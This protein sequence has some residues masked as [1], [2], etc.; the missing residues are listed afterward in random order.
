MPGKGRW[1]DGELTGHVTSS[2]DSGDECRMNALFLHFPSVLGPQPMGLGL[3]HSVYGE[4]G[5]P[6]SGHL[7][8]EHLYK[9]PG[10]C[11]HG[12]LN[13]AELTRVDHQD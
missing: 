12:I 9:T 3:P 13:P 10:M 7:Y 4:M 1:Q 8:W 6:H 2:Q 5:L 11:F